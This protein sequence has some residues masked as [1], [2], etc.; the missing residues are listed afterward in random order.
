MEIETIKKKK[1]T[2]RDILGDRKPRKEIRS[3]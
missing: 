2:S 1:N 3:Q